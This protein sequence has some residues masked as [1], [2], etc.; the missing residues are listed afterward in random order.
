MIPVID[1]FAGPGG[2]GEGFSVLRDVKNRPVFKIGLSI[3]KEPIAH[4]TLLLR[5]FFRQFDRPSIPDEYYACVRGE[6]TI[7]AL[8]SKH[9]HEA[10]VARKEAIC[11]NLGKHDWKEI[12][13]QIEDAIGGSCNWVL[14]G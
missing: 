13:Q 10:D 4:Q 14:I 11:A 1:I 7:E 5:S 8:F 12:D 6:L 3:E 2:L 9:P